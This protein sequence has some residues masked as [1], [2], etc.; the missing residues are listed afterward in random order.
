MFFWTCLVPL[1]LCS[2]LLIN[3]ATAAT[4]DSLT[5]TGD[6]ALIALNGPWRFHT[7]DDPLWADPNFD[8]SAWQTV[9]LTAPP[10][11]HDSDVGLTGYM[12]GWQ[13]SGHRGYAG[14]AWYRMR[15]SVEALPREALALC[16]PFY[17]DSAYQVF[18]NGRLLGGMG[19]FSGETPVAYSMHRPKIFALPPSIEPASSHDPGEALVAI[20]VWMG[21]WALQSAETGGIHIAPVIGTA[22]AAESLYRQ[23]W[24]QIIRGYSVDAVEGLLF[25]LLAI[26]ALSLIPLDRSNRAYPWL[27]AAL[28]LL[29]LARANQAIFCWGQFETVHGFE[30]ATI[31]LL[32]PLS[33]ATWTMTWRTWLRLSTYAWMPAVI[34][35]LTVLYIAA[36]SLR[37]SWFYGVFPPPL[38]AA[39]HF[40]SM[41]V[42]LVFVLLTLLIIHRGVTARGREKWLALAAIL[43]MSV[44]LFAQELSMLH[45]PGIWFPFGVGVS[46]TEYA[47]AAFDVVLIVLL[48]RRRD[49]LLRHPAPVGSSCS[50][51]AACV[52]ADPSARL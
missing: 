36:E 6:P 30:L 44:G 46:R 42:R 25:V 43:L 18:V 8:D 3:R 32:V 50:T 24:Q 34:A 41:S 5:A 28:I 14:Y 17:V 22:S 21:P 4:A 27:A 31:V 51:P 52:P 37:R 10:A 26:M 23:Q 12:P 7:G 20:R 38:T 11:A 19:N 29:G 45:I 48:L 47:Y 16:G 33:L 35:A 1:A 13:A 15:V 39:A 40:C 9:D 2:S 49:L